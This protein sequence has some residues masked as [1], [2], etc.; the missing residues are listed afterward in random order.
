MLLSQPQIALP[1]LFPVGKNGIR[2]VTVGIYYLN[3]AVAKHPAGPSE[4]LHC[5]SH[6]DQ[7]PYLLLEFYAVK[8][9]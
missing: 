5:I 6:P 7:N 9:L 8:W 2:E 4:L 1:P 3:L